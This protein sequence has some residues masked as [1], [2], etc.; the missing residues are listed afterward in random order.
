M[1]I[2]L[3]NTIWNPTL[4]FLESGTF[5]WNPELFFESKFEFENSFFRIQN[6]IR[7]FFG[8][9]NRILKAIFGIQNG[10]RWNPKWNPAILFLNPNWNPVPN[11]WN[12]NGIRRYFLESKIESA[13]IFGIRCHI[14]D[15]G[16][17]K[18]NKR[19]PGGGGSQ[20]VTVN[21]EKPDYLPHFVPNVGQKLLLF[22][23]KWVFLGKMS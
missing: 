14:Y 3:K 18:S 6:G 21:G 20:T 19:W 4:C 9:R 2:C 15:S 8:I 12:P 13:V 23:I 1:T 22:S 10:I 17:E 11:F 5:F 7:S 16:Y